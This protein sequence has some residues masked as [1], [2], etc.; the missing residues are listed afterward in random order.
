MD[1]T[2]VPSRS[3][4]HNVEDL[5]VLREGFDWEEVKKDFSW[6][7]TGKVNAAYETIDRHAENPDKK[8]QVALLYSAPDREERLTFEQLSKQS[9]KTANMFKKYGIQKGDRVFLFMPRSPEF[10]AN[11]FGI[12]KVGGD[13]WTFI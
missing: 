2:K 7:K 10:Y 11:F 5:E 6:Y 3:G 12:L 13:C 9:N 8:D 4:S 1:M